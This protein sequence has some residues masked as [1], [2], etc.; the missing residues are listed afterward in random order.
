MRA[1]MRNYYDLALMFRPDAVQD[2]MAGFLLDREVQEADWLLA[3]G[4]GFRSMGLN[5]TK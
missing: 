4:R 3:Q 1:L 5:T 2:R